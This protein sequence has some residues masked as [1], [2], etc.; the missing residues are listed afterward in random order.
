M[1]RNDKRTP[2]DFSGGANP[3]EANKLGRRAL[4]SVFGFLEIAGDR[5]TYLGDFGP[6]RGWFSEGLVKGTFPTSFQPE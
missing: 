5:E 4:R 2:R 1:S 6:R 3:A